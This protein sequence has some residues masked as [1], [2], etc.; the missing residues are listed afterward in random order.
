MIPGL[1]YIKDFISEQEEISLI[2]KIDS[3]PWL[4][5]LRRRTQHYGYKYD[6]TKKRIDSESYVGP[7]PEWIEPY[8]S[9]LVKHGFF[10]VKPDQVIIN[11]YEPGQG[12]SQHVDCVPCFNSTVASLSLLSSCIMDFEELGTRKKLQ[13]R[14]DPKSML[15]LSGPARYDWMHSIAP[16]VEDVTEDEVI[17]RSRRVSLTFRKVIL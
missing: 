8:C 5:D 7:I 12:I 14:L 16:R 6:Y 2:K 15:V 9:K 4:T 10:D 17:S 13:G 11:E 3:L 1:R